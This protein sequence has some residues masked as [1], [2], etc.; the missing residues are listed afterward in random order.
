MADDDDPFGKPAPSSSGSG[1]Y[2]LADT[3]GDVAASVASKGAQGALQGLGTPGDIVKGSQWLSD[4]LMGPVAGYLGEQFE[5]HIAG[6]SDEQIDRIRQNREKRISGEYETPHLMPSSQDLIGRA[7]SVVPG[8]DYQ[9]KTIPG[10]YLGSA[11]EVAAN[12]TNYLGP[13]GLVGKAAAGV[14]SGLGAQA[15]E[16]ITGG[17]VGRFVGG[18]AA[19]L[20]A[21]RLTGTSARA[22]AQA[23]NAATETALSDIE[24]AYKQGYADLRANPVPL[25]RGVVSAQGAK[26]REALVK[27]G[28]FRPFT[29]PKTFKTLDL[30]ENAGTT[31]KQLAK[32]VGT[33]G[34]SSTNEILS[35]RDTLNKI[36]RTVP[37]EKAA[38][39][40]AI[41]HIDN[42]LDNIPGINTRARQARGD[43]RAAA[44]VKDLDSMMINAV[45]DAK[46]T[47]GSV[48]K[49]IRVELNRMLQDDSIPK[50][51]EERQAMTD[52]LDGG[53]P[54]SMAGLGERHAFW[55]TLWALLNNHPIHAAISLMPRIMGGGVDRANLTRQV[56][57]LRSDILRRAPSGSGV[58]REAVPNLLQSAAP[59]AVRAYDALGPGE[60]DPFAQ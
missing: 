43:Y 54:Q 44:R 12:P 8:I 52:M 19:P 27:D 23:K 59:Q 55:W 17:P 41:E 36:A 13:G 7:E 39:S 58:P 10:R 38:A 29:D 21:G 33:K 51:P 49:A 6:M 35:V 57:D 56:Q 24:T 4:H 26:I 28:G 34:Q 48:P 32:R 5:R 47:G 50:S 31:G 45:N 18:L 42:Y 11:A 46:A 37:D 1:V 3:A 9:P 25:G 60:D 16:D 14:V 30:L 40:A 15:G 53:L 2:S 22:E 20:A